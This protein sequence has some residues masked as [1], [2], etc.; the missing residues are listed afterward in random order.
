MPFTTYAEL[1]TA[2]QTWQDRQDLSSNVPDFIRLFEAYAN[3][4]IGDVRQELSYATLTPD[5]NGEATL[6]TDYKQW[7]RVTYMGSSRRELNYVEPSQLVTDYPD[8]PSGIPADFTIEGSKIIIRPLDTT[9]IQLAYYGTIG[10]LSVATN[11]LFDE[12]PDVYLAGAL[13][14]LCA[15]AEDPPWTTYWQN[16]R[17]AGIAAIRAAA[18]KAKHSRIAQR[19]EGPTP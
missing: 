9:D 14:E 19:V 8:L 1:Q 11:W 3:D 17:D 18:K 5:A 4:E 10:P 16:R 13:T 2:V 7:E 12:R 6:P 15:F